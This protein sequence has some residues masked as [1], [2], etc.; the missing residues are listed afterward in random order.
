MQDENETNNLFQVALTLSSS[1]RP[2]DSTTAAYTFKVL[3]H[4]PA[5]FDILK[6]HSTRQHRKWN[7]DKNEAGCQKEAVIYKE[8]SITGSEAVT[9]HIEC[10]RVT[11]TQTEADVMMETSR[12]RDFMAFSC[13]INNIENNNLGRSC[14]LLVT[15][16]NRL[17]EQAAVA[18]SNLIVAAANSPLYP[19]MQCMRYCLADIDF[20]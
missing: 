3:I 4:Q 14:M 10:Q 15:L 13:I 8:A 17:Q 1:T 7:D 19:T 6:S 16:L 11:E 9:Q 20:R 18:K 2:Q 5:I 12:L